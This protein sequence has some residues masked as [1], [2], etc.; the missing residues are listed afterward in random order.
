MK[1]FFL[2]ALS[3]LPNVVNIYTL[4]AFVVTIGA[5]L[6]LSLKVKRNKQL[7][8]KLKE[9]PEQDRLEALKREMGGAFVKDLSPD[10]YLRLKTRQYYFFGFVSFL[11][12]LGFLVFTVR[13]LFSQSSPYPLTDIPLKVN[14]TWKGYYICP[15]GRTEASLKITSIFRDKERNITVMSDFY[16]FPIRDGKK[17]ETSIKLQGYY[18]PEERKL[19]LEPFGEWIKNPDN[20]YQKVGMIGSILDN[21]GKYT[22]VM[23]E[24]GHTISHCPEFSFLLDP[25]L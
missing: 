21:G 25:M 3:A 13:E 19:E 4:L 5:M 23:S 22:G 20:Y 10:A 16:A 15:Q 7:L 24:G 11:L 18:K 8:E 17:E 6:I 14:Q 2:Q 9:L 12:F 1:D